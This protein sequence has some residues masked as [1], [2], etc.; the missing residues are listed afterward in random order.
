MAEKLRVDAVELEQFMKLL[1]GSV[2][3]L[4]GLRS[5]LA[6]ATVG[7]L[8]TDD[9]DKACEDFQED[10]KYGAEQIGEQTEDLSKLIEQ[11]KNAFMEVEAA[12]AKA[13]NK[14]GKTKDDVVEIP[15]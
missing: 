3:S 2:R 11:N 15:R 9:L 7:G 4:K 8:G 10:W 1:D 12:L 5:A 6:D 13:M 14:A